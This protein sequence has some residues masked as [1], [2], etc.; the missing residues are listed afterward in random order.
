MCNV[1]A[2]LSLLTA[3]SHP[4]K[5]FS[6]SLWFNVFYWVMLPDCQH[7][8]CPWLVFVVMVLLLARVCEDNVIYLNIFQVRASMEQLQQMTI[9]M[10]QRW[11]YLKPKWKETA[12]FEWIF[13]NC[14]ISVLHILNLFIIRKIALPSQTF[15]PAAALLNGDFL[16]DFNEQINIKAQ[17]WS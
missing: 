16:P 8:L 7:C 12:Q 17:N 10:F 11:Q 2:V 13:F 5:A 3:S 1:F 14:R 6:S 4:N 15:K 9:N